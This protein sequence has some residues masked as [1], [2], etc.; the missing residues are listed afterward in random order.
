MKRL[1]NLFGLLLG[2]M[3]MTSCSSDVMNANIDSDA[4]MTRGTSTNDQ[5]GETMILGA[6][7]CNEISK[8]Q[9]AIDYGISN[10]EVDIHVSRESGS[11]VLMIGHELETSTGQTFEEY[12]D[13]LMLMKPDF[14]FLWLDFKDLSTDEN[15]AII[16]ETLHRLDAK[17]NIKQRVLVESRYIT[18]L[19]SFA[20]D[21]WHVS[22]YST[23]SSLVGKTEQEQKEICDGWLKS[24]EENNVD[25]ISFDS[26][27]YLP[28]KKNFENAQV[29]GRPVR[30]YA[31]NYRIYYTDPDLAE[32]LKKYSHLTVLIIGFPN[33]QILKLIA[34]IEFADKGA[35]TNMDKP[36]SSL[37]VAE[38]VTNA[39]ATRWNSQYQ[40][41]EAVF[42]GT[43]FFYVPYSKTD[44]IGRAM[45]A[46]FSMEILFSPDGGVN[47]FSS[48]ESG[49]MGYEITAANQLAFYYRANNNW[50]L[51]NNNFQ[52][53]IEIGKDIY[54]HAVV[55]YDKTTFKFYLNGTKVKEVKVSGTFN[56]PKK[57]L[58]PDYLLGIGGDYRDSATPSI[59]NP[60][61]GKIV[62]A[63]F[64][65][66]V[67]K[68]EDIE[69]MNQ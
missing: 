66:G 64:Y 13:D 39:I 47:P 10:Y 17:Y 40:K 49:G 26:D 33:E 58:A 24:M 21:G 56:F 61:R 1:K 16:S 48:M 9:D 62:Y 25:G 14:N 3:I 54:Y 68:A 42:D 57:D 12:F 30:Q 20:N 28:M 4:P 38:G 35:A 52:T 18:H 5:F 41:Y 45:N 69:K 27:V 65:K 2:T 46:M 63:K 50:V 60:F 59:Q 37:P 34:D 11:P 31:W 44:A 15:E 67:L 7:K 6:H 32:Q 23:W 29:N 53:P 22:F 19:T 43:N 51:P 36:V 55:T 8:L